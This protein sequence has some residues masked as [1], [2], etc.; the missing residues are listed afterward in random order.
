M[1]LTDEQRAEL[2]ALGPET[3]RAKLIQVGPGRGA[4]LA[5]LQFSRRL[6]CSG[7]GGRRFKSCHSDHCLTTLGNWTA[8]AFAT[9]WQLVGSIGGPNSQARRFAMR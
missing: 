1:P 5:D 9:D 2:E 3:V 6:T 7:R 8:T 4:S